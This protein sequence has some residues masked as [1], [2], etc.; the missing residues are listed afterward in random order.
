M[1]IDKRTYLVGC[2]ASS[3]EATKTMPDGLDYE[4][5]IVSL[6][7]Q[8]IDKMEQTIM[9]GS[10]RILFSPVADPII[11]SLYWM[12]DYGPEQVTLLKTEDGRHRVQLASG[13]VQFTARLYDCR[14]TL[15]EDHE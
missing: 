8:L 6:A 1:N 10:R 3:F 12:L 5:Y 9:P 14:W 11:G 7:D 4:D 15:K 13:S 2:I